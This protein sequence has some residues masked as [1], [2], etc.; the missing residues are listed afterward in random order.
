MQ[1]LAL[2]IGGANIK[3]ADGLGY[4]ATY[5]F[6][7][8]K[9]SVKL[10]KQLRAIISESPAADHLAIT[11]TGELADCFAS[12]ADGVKHILDAVASAADNRH[13][14]VYLHD[15]RQVTPQVAA[16]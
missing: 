2:D 3:V 5:A 13:T 11:M 8:W 16:M 1:Y 7:L 12:K 4:S 9:E 14:R 6:P 15:G 10:S